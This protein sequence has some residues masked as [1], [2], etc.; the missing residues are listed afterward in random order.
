MGH[1]RIEK[2]RIKPIEN[3]TPKEG[4]NADVE[5]A[6]LVPPESS[7]PSE[8]EDTEY[9]AVKKLRFDTDTKDDQVLAVSHSKLKRLFASENVK[10]WMFFPQAIRP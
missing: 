3:T 6:I 9:V 8:S 4:G 7:N 2:T 5:A 1:L 10:Q